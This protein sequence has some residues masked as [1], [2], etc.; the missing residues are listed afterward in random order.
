VRRYLILTLTVTN[1]LFL[2]YIFDASEHHIEHNLA[3]NF[4]FKEHLGA[5]EH[6]VDNPGLHSL[7]THCRIYLYHSSQYSAEEFTLNA[8][9]SLFYCAY[10]CVSQHPQK[11][12]SNNVL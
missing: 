1:V 11:S 7:H 12:G 3:R 8:Y 10:I 4:L 5:R 2:S 9:L 6:Q